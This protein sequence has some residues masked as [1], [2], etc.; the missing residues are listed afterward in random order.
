MGIQDIN[1]FLK[2]QGVS[3]KTLLRPEDFTGY[4]IVIDASLWICVNTPSLYRTALTHLVDPVD[5]EIDRTIILDRLIQQAIK[6][7]LFW[8]KAGVTPVWVWEGGAPPDKDITRA[9]RR[10]T[11]E[12]V[13]NKVEVLRQE[14]R[15]IDPLFRSSQKIEELKRAI[16]NA[17]KVIPE[18]AMYLKGM[19]EGLGLPSITAPEGV[20]ADPICAALC[21]ELLAAATWSTDT[22]HYAYGTPILLTG[23]GPRDEMGDTIEAAIIP[24]IREHFKWTQEKLR[25]F[26]IISGCDY[27][28]RIPNYGCKK[29][30]KLLLENNGDIIE[31]VEKRTDLKVDNLRAARCRELLTAPASGYTHDHIKLNIDKRTFAAN[32][33]LLVEQ[34][35]LQSYFNELIKLVNDLPEPNL[36]V[37]SE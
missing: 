24:S 20:E 11:Y 27:N 25:D 4:R 15:P 12:K 16:V 35:R 34:Y 14:L 22:D 33:R 8:L 18:E 19:I 23:Y 21:L 36:V 10:E 31:I 28:H 37:L 13:R 5:G 2:D 26:C 1:T 30:Y 9:D 29:G 6:F 32:I 3:F 7:Q 17:G